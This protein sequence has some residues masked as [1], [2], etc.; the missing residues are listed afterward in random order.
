MCQTSRPRQFIIVLDL[1]L[2]KVV[3]TLSRHVP[4][5]SLSP[6]SP[7]RGGSNQANPSPFVRFVLLF[8]YVC[9]ALCHPVMILDSLQKCLLPKE[10]FVLL[11]T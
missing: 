8:I 5:S 6:D 4:T 1:K 2:N 9:Q 10:E 3:L 7:I 11:N